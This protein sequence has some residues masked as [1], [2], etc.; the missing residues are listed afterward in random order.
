MLGLSV[1][2][3]SYLIKK[4]K[5]IASYFKIFLRKITLMVSSQIGQVLIPHSLVKLKYTHPLLIDLLFSTR[6]GFFKVNYFII[7]AYSVIEFS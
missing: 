7:Y 5:D 6:F 4:N 1:E 2:Y 3:L